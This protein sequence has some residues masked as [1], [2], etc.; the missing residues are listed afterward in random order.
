MLQGDRTTTTT[1]TDEQLRAGILAADVITLLPA[2]ANLQGDLSVQLDDLRPDPLLL[3]QPDAG[4]T[5]AQLEAARS[6]AFEA[7][8]RHRDRGA[9]PAPDPTPEA[10]HA[11][12]EFLVGPATDE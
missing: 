6:L 3:M 12:I 7:L 10:L 11:M 2:Y 9:P 1:A 4:F 5:D 8:V